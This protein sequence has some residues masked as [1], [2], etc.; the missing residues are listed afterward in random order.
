M[1][2]D[3]DAFLNQHGIQVLRFENR[4]VFEYPEDIIGDILEFIDKR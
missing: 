1:D 3:R 4:W 2:A